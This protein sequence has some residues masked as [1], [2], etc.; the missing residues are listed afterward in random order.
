MSPT[1][2]TA[3]S[4]NDCGFAETLLFGSNASAEAQICGPN[5]NDSSRRGANHFGFVAKSSDRSQD[6]VLRSN[7]V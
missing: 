5:C 3:T 6:F 7:T 2:S 4:Q 1:S